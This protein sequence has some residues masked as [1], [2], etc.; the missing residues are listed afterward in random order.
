MTV[1][2][3]QVDRAE[4]PARRAGECQPRKAGR[5]RGADCRVEPQGPAA[6]L[7]RIPDGDGLLSLGNCLALDLGALCLGRSSCGGALAFLALG[8]LVPWRKD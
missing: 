7:P 4:L 2:S 6:G 8:G 5:N 1:E 3:A